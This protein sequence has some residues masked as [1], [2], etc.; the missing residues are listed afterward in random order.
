MNTIKF[1]NHEYEVLSFSR[2]TYFNGNEINSTVNCQIKTSNITEL[3]ELAQETISTLQI[4]HDNELIYN[5]GNLSGRLV[6]IDEY[7]AEDRINISLNCSFDV[8]TG[9]DAEPV[10]E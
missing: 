3:Y 5:L 10:Q 8:E 6:T 9:A 2:N 4:Y 1:N 7:L